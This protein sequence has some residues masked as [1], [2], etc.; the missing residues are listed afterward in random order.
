MKFSYN[1]VQEYLDKELPSAKDLISILSLKSFEVES[2]KKINKDFVLDIDIT[3]NRV[4]DCSS[5]IGIAREMAA[6][7]DYKLRLP[8]FKIRENSKL[9]AKDIVSIEVR[10]KEACPRYSAR[11]ITD[12]KIGDSPDWLK[13]K[14]E[15]C[16]LQSINNAVDIANY[17]MLETGQPL[18]I[19]D[20]DK[21]EHKKLIVRFA[22]KGEK[23]TTLDEQNFKLNES[24]LVIADAK[25]PVALAGIKGGK[26]PGVDSQ[27]KTI[28]LESANFNPVIIRKA[29]QFL[30]LKTDASWRFEH[31]I[32]ANLTEPAINRAA[33]LIQELASG[34]I[35][36]GI[37]DFYPEKIKPK[38]IFLDIDNVEKLLG[39]RIP[40]KQ[41]KNI[42]TKLGFKLIASKTVSGKIAVEVPTSRLDIS[43]PEDLIEEIGRIYGYE[44][45][46]VAAPKICLIPPEKNMNIF[47][48]EFSKDIL[49]ENRFS[50]VLNYSFI[51]EAQAKTF[52][53]EI[54]KLL[55]I[56][57]PLS[58]NQQ[59]LCPSLVP[60][61]MRNVKTNFNYFSE[62]K[63][64]EMGKIF[65]RATN[66]RKQKSKPQTVVQGN[67]LAV[68]EQRFLSGLIAR[69][70]DGNQ[71]FYE[72]KGVIDDLLNKMGITNVWYD[73]YEPTPEQTKI[74]VWDIGKSA[75]IKVNDKE[76]GF[77]GQ[78]SP[79]ILK[80]LDITGDVVLFDI[81]FDTLQKLV[82]EEHEYQLIS[83]YPSAMRD[84][85]ILVPKETKV[86]D[87]FN[88][89][90][91]I[92]GS[93]VRDIDLFDIYQGDEL[94]GD[95]KSF[96]FHIVYQAKDRTLESKEIETIHGKIVKALEQNLEW[97]VRK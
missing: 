29:S 86:V 75:E 54:D 24:I 85:S 35:A 1:W 46:P 26:G 87:V 62:F 15:I 72:L 22:E 41:I 68:I 63:I 33:K 74:C 78:I 55:E 44:K 14:L 3:S 61:L 49:Q 25:R 64:F 36:Q 95:K 97:E 69:T 12:I 9:L 27:T 82:S 52:G 65:S 79:K 17:V 76:V 19:F 28:V 4:C 84:L 18:H 7:M 56:E 93:L 60:N 21:L 91:R 10:D 5:H 51:S 89:M 81:D 88:V 32:D 83:P 40:L 48:E 59:Y 94:H 13:K 37:V 73:E 8:D 71:S 23:I 57:N 43:I 30:K 66:L 45:I 11:V 34:K 53:Y 16:G 2:I 92:G 39:G 31:G 38:K 80:K 90:N 50:E 96:A 77:L 6:I 47:W 42:L 58:S 67:G 70:K 20:L